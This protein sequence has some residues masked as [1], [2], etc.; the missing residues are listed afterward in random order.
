MPT[1]TLTARRIAAIAVEAGQ[2]DYWDTIVP[3]LALRVGAGGT[4]TYIVRYRAN[5]KQR[6]L[7]IGK[8]PHIT[9]ADAR[10]KAREKLSAALAGDDPASSRALHRSKDSSFR[11]LCDEVQAARTDWREKTRRERKRIIESELLPKWGD[12]AAGSISRRDVV[13]LVEHIARRAPV[14]ANRT[15]ATIKMVFNVGVDREFPGLETNPAYR[16]KPQPEGRRTRF[17]TR[18]EIGLVWGLLEDETLSTRAL[19]RF[20]LLTAQRVG[21]VRLMRWSDIGKDDVWSIPASAFKGRRPHLVPLSREARAVLED[22]RPITGDIVHV[23]LGRGGK[24]GRAS[25]NKALQRVRERSELPNWTI[26]DFRT[27]FRTHA[28]RAQRPKDNRDPA[29][30]GIAPHIADAVL[31]HKEASLGFDRYTAEPERYLLSE[32]RDAL[33]KWGVFVMNAV[34]GSSKKQ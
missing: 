33:E 24:H 1:E 30:L 27:T 12:R 16:L 13:Q 8:H 20:T 4:K 11:A 26:H 15:L 6:R 18:D 9:L 17:L 10:E 25:I 14:M 23:F 21:S 32:K 3:G 29:G 34:K 5:G 19:L 7:T 2:V 31:G 22:L 28:T